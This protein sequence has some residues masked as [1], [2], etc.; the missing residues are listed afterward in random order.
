MSWSVRGTY[1]HFSSSAGRINC[2]GR[3]SSRN[4]DSALAR[5]ATSSADGHEPPTISENRPHSASTAAG[6]ASRARTC[7]SPA[8]GRREPRTAS[9]RQPDHPTPPSRLSRPAAP[10]HQPRRRAP[11]RARAATGR[12]SS[13]LSAET[14]RTFP[15][16]D[17]PAEYESA[18]TC[19]LWRLPE[20]PVLSLVSTR[21]SVSDPEAREIEPGRCARSQTPSRFA[22]RH[23]AV[24]LRRQPGEG[25]AFRQ[26]AGRA[27]GVEGRG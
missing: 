18:Q 22:V 27:G 26:M 25:S 4:R 17:N 14:A 5:T 9:R 11:C 21:R 23:L 10:A 24:G 6:S 2:A 12:A 1:T 19:A 8:A 7:G 16:D 15:D 3:G 20:S 13:T